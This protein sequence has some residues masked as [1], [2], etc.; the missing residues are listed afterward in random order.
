M[1]T[2]SSDTQ[3]DSDLAIRA[4]EERARRARWQDYFTTAWTRL[5]AQGGPSCDA[6]GACLYRSDNHRVCGAGAL[7][8]DEKYVPAMEN[9]TINARIFRGMFPDEDYGAVYE[10]QRAHDG[11]VSSLRCDRAHTAMNTPEFDA[12]WLPL[13]EDEM[14]RVASRNGYTV[15]T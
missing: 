6:N 14:R 12:A 8:S 13:W 1:N 10:L 3:A 5:H 7:F 11:V 15:P 9:E 4:T 2:D